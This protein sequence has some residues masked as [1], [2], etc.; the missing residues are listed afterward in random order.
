MT[1]GAG[2]AGGAAGVA[3]AGGVGAAGWTAG[4]V[5]LGAGEG[6]SKGA[7]VGATVTGVGGVTGLG[8]GGKG[9]G[10]GGS[11]FGAAGSVAGCMSCTTITGNS[12]GDGFCCKTFDA[13]STS[14]AACSASVAAMAVPVRRE[15]MLWRC[16]LSASRAHPACQTSPFFWFAK[17]VLH[18][19]CRVR[20]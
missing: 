5:G 20:R 10:G 11:G 1:G 19:G 17:N 9:L 13:N 7:G 14:N 8:G 12:G 3:G 2:G 6:V 4:A 15:I 16:V 18:A